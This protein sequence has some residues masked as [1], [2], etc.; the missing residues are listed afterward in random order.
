MA[1]MRDWQIERFVLGE[2]PPAEQEKVALAVA[3]DPALRARV[4]AIEASSR[5]IL[6]AHPARAAAS[7]IHERLSAT[8]SPAPSW[9]RRL[10]FAAAASLAVASV[11]VFVRPHGGGG[12][13]VPAET[14]IK[15]LRPRLGVFRQTPAGIEALAEGALAREGD[16]VQL[17]YQAAGRPFGVI[18]SIDGRGTVTVHHP[19]DGRQAA[20]LVPGQPVR[21]SFAYRLD[22]APGWERFVLVT[23]ERPFDVAPVADAAARLAAS[24][25]PG[26]APLVLPSSL[27][28]SSFTLTKDDRP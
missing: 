17:T 11:A 6:A 16:L 20:R 23:A 14:R 12:L 13:E 19:R 27:E 3:S 7:V 26:T 21:L 15:G 28:Q 5:E 9:G 2:L 4:D 25:A 10:A 18:L 24:G 8:A 1:E 22:D